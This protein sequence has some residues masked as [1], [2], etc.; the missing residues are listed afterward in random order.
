MIRIDRWLLLLILLSLVSIFWVN[1]LYQVPRNTYQMFLNLSPEQL[2]KIIQ[3]SEEYLKDNPEDIAGLLQLG[4]ALS[5]RGKEF[6]SR[7]INSLERARDLG[8]S[9]PNLFAVLGQLYEKNGIVEE[10]ILN[11]KRYLA[12]YPKDREYR[13]RLSNIYFYLEQIDE[14]IDELEN[15]YRFYSRDP[16]ILLNL[17]RCYL[18]KG[19]VE[20]AAE[21]MS[22]LEAVSSQLPPEGNYLLG[23][24]ALAKEN[25]SQAVIAYQKELNLNQN[26][27]PAYIGLAKAYEK[28]NNKEEAIRTWKKVIQL[29]PNNKEAKESLQSQQRKAVK[30]TGIRK[31]K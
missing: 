27:I 26:F 3:Q 17:T 20:D 14:A 1:F 7:A 30:R 21:K 10:A 15:I 9:D 5:R 13:I 29:D 19:L 6:F 11:Y 12:H 28:S 23:E 22:D 24:L 31:I 4:F 8:A 2:D 25:Y 18:K 16:V